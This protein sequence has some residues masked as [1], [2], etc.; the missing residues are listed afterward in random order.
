MA[1]MINKRLEDEI[2]ERLNAPA[3]RTGRAK[4]FYVKG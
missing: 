3:E 2:V 1:S 4:T